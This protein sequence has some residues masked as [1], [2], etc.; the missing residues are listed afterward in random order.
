MNT[1]IFGQYSSLDDMWHA[2]VA[3][4]LRQPVVGSRDGTCREVLGAQFHLIDPRRS[5][6]R[7]HRRA[8]SPY[9]AAAEVLWYMGGRADVSMMTRYAPQYTRFA[10]PNGRVYGAYGSRLFNVDQGV[11][12]DYLEDAKRAL[13]KDGETRRCVVSLWRPDDLPDGFN[14]EIKDVPCTLTWQ[15]LVRGDRLHMIVNMRS[16]DVWLGMPYDV[17]WNCL[18]QRVMSWE[19]GLQL[20]TYVHQCGSLHL[21]ERD[22]IKA[23]I[24][25][26]V[27][28]EDCEP[29]WVDWTAADRPDDFVRLKTASRVEA[30]VRGNDDGTHPPLGVVG[31]A[32]VELCRAFLHR[33]SVHTTDVDPVL[34]DAAT[35][36]DLQRDRLGDR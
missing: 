18:V 11:P 21:Y 17:F 13:S 34:A 8:A 36:Y 32:L 2:S 16:Q 23:H 26:G 10:Q 14:P 25:E 4:L 30:Q 1:M 24:A 20:G 35:V 15:F 12:Y 22:M 5:W 7:N 28:Q 27:P 33:D 31:G 19:L 9:Y 3:C 29:L 6:L